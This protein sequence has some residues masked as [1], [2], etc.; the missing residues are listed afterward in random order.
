[1]LLTDKL[2]QVVS[3]VTGNVKSVA[4]TIFQDDEFLFKLADFENCCAVAHT[5]AVDTMHYII[6]L[7]WCDKL[8]FR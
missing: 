3:L 1:M 6:P 8:R 5:N 4:V 7:F 2:L